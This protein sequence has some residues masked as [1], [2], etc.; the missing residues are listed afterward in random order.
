MTHHH[1]HEGEAHPSPA[2]TPSLIRLSAPRRLALVG[3]MIAL[4]WAA[5]FWATR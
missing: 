4:I 3:A 2:I 5:C 1:H